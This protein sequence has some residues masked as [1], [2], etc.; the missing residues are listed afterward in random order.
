LYVI[1][2]I[3]DTARAAYGQGTSVATRLKGVAAATDRA[4]ESRGE[5][6]RAV[7]GGKR[8]MDS[9]CNGERESIAR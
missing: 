8:A 2:R 1:T 3:C 7:E 6:W 5:P 9:M 4:V